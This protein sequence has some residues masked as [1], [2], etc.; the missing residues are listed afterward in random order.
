MSIEYFCKCGSPMPCTR[1]SIKQDAQGVRIYG[2]RWSRFRNAM[3]RQLEYALCAN[4]FGLHDGEVR[5]THT[6]DH[7]TP[8][9]G[10]EDPTF[11][12]G[13]FQGL[14]KECDHHKTALD[15]KEGMTRAR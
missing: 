4:P 7:I 1:H 8:V 10:P 6:L 2:W 9:T 5:Q 15:R 13:P 11:W 12:I 3:V 14:C